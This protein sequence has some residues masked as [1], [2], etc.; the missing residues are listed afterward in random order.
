MKHSARQRTLLTLTLLILMLV[1]IAPAA[2]APYALPDG[3]TAAILLSG[4]Y[5]QDFDTLV[6][7]GTSS[8]LPG[9]WALAEGGTNANATYTAGT[10]SST[11]GDTYSFGAS[12][13]TE[14]AFGT[15]QSGSLVPTIGAEFQNA[16]NAVITSLA[17]GYNCEHWRIG[18]T[19]RGAADR[20]DLQYSTDATSLTTGT[21]IDVDALDCLSTV[22]SGTAGA[23]DGNS[24]RTAVSNNIG[25]LS[26]ANG[27]G[28]WLRWT[29]FNIS[30][31]D[32]GLGIDDFVI[33]PASSGGDAA[34]SVTS[35]VP[36]NNAP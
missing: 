3:P 30:G 26:I 24:N 35:T 6:S 7:S 5:S 10:G 28:F 9:G 31:S 22:T 20:L 19:S 4:T 14:R 25:G 34:P 29:D 17:I 13:N 16:T 12:S 21:W 2:A 36:A 15:L 27:N 1:S 18:V 33:T 23:L 32:D 11:A 8:V